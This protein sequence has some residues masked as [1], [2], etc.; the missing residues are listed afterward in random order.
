[1][2]DY[3]VQ[4]VKCVLFMLYAGKIVIE[5]VNRAIIESIISDLGITR[6]F[7]LRK[8][9]PGDFTFPPRLRFFELTS[10]ITQTPHEED[11]NVVNLG[12]TMAPLCYRLQ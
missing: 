2:L 11:D 10:G 9:T 5:N 8:V 6:N 12:K 3:A 1:M 4:H 7:D